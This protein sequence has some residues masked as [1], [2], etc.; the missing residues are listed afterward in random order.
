MAE[1]KELIKEICEEKN[2]S[3]NLLSKNWIIQLKKDEKINYIV[4]MKF[5]L[6]GNSSAMICDDKYAMYEVLK[7]NHVPTVECK[8]IYNPRVKD[9][10]SDLK[11]EK[12]ITE[13]LNKCGKVVVKDATGTFG[14]NVYCCEAYFEIKDALDEIFNKKKTAIISP[15][16]NILG[17]YRCICLDDTCELV[18]E[19]VRASDNWKHNLSNGASPHIVEDAN[20]KQSLVKFALQIMKI[21]NIRFASVDIIDTQEGL[22]LLEVNSGVCM[23]SFMLQVENGKEIAKQIYSKAIDK[24]F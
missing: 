19:K 15:F 23:N 21:I 22:M 6:N 24:M 13:Y 16:V 17:E 7:N 9:Y 18:Y 12:E 3:Y 10:E 8:L 1:F 14:R 11:D 5:S 20:L 4:G 2:I